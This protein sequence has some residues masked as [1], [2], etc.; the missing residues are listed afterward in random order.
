MDTFTIMVVALGIAVGINIIAKKLHIPVVIGYILTGVTIL[1]TFSLHEAAKSNT[2][3]HIAE[4]GIVFLMFM[5]GL[6]FSAD[7]IKQLRREVL[8]FGVLQ[9]VV[10]LILCF[11][12]CLYLFNINTKTSLIVASALALSSTAIVLKSFNETKEI[13]TQYGK[14]VLG[15]L[16]FQ[17]IAVIPI[18]LMITI[19]SDSSKDISELLFQTFVSACVVLFILFVPGKKLIS[20]FLRFAANTKLD[21][22]FVASVLFIVMSTSLLVSF[23]GF[24]Y[25]LGAFIAGMIIAETKYK[26]RVESDLVHF[27]DLLLG[28]FF[29]TVGMQVNLQFLF[30][31]I[32]NIAILLIS[33]MTIKTVIIY[34]LLRFFKDVENS[35]KSA[36][37]LSQ[38]GEFSFAIF[39][40]SS[41]HNIIDQ[42]IQQLLIL[43]VIFSMILTPFILKN[44]NFI[45]SFF[46]KTDEEN[47]KLN[48]Y[49]AGIRNHVVICGYGTFGSEIV[50]YL[51]GHDIKYIAVDYNLKNVEIGIQ[52][53]ENV[54]Y[55]D[56]SKKSI[57]EKLYIEDSVAVVIAVDNTDKIRI[58]CENI[59]RL[60][61][62]VN[63]IVKIKSEEEALLIDDLNIHKI[64]NEKKE[65]AKMLAHAALSCEYMRLK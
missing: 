54:F 9:V 3:T 65:I 21:E 44:L 64:I 35:L 28:F 24:S 15:I 37:S 51:K 41:T 49:I 38:V 48:R 32:L 45:T 31:N 50:K 27:R 12:I 1:Y 30:A 2:L 46:I 26:Y 36:I 60:Y 25:S 62:N 4:F 57:L 7:K 56:V 39:A 6:E 14:S 5:I 52:R 17:D 59:S 33:V 16:I 18:L 55:G 10:S 19:I 40:L 34:L 47:E 11:I 22:V 58:I 61:P 42:N 8:I 23:F 53:G 29:I 63:I 20:I 43:V 13:H